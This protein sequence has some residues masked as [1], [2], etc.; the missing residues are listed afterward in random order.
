MARV[1]QLFLWNLDESYCNCTDTSEWLIKFNES[2]FEDISEEVSKGMKYD[3]LEHSAS[4][5]KVEGLILLWAIHLRAGLDPCG[6]LQHR[7]FCE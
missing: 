6:F 3:Y 5:T 1:G 2:L 4:N 7:I